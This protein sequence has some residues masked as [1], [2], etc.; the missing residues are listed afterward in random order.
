MLDRYY[1]DDINLLN[2]FIGNKKYITIDYI[3]NDEQVQTIIDGLNGED[4]RAFINLN[5]TL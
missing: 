1:I 5:L 4:E 3:T 2:T